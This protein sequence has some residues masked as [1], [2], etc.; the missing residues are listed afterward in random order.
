MLM[1]VPW[2]AG[3]PA[4]GDWAMIV[5]SGA[6]ALSR[7]N[8]PMSRPARLSRDCASAGVRPTKSG[9][10]DCADGLPP[11][12]VTTTSTIVPGLTDWPRGGDW[13]TMP[14]PGQALDRR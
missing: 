10:A 3:D 5:P 4:A 14:P 8:C 6:A 2:E 9:T 7:S 11:V 12:A 1:R 13:A